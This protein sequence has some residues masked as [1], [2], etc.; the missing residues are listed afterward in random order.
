MISGILR[1]GHVRP[2]V[3][4]LAF[5][6]LVAASLAPPPA[7]AQSGYL[8]SSELE[9]LVAP[10]A[11][12]PDPLIAELLPAATYPDEVADAADYVDAHGATDKNIDRQPWDASVKAIAHYPDAINKMA[13]DMD[14][15]ADLG[16]AFLA[17]PED[18]MDAIQT[19]RGVAKDRGV[20]KT[21]EQQTVVYEEQNIRVVP[22]S[23]Q[24]I[25]VPQYQPQVVYIEDDDD[26]PSWGGAIAAS[27]ISFGVGM[28]VGSW[29]H[30]DCNWYGGG[31]YHAGWYGGY[32][33]WNSYRSGNI[34]IN[35]DVN[36]NRQV[37][38]Y[39]NF[40]NWNHD[41]NRYRNDINKYGDRYNNRYRDQNR[42]KNKDKVRNDRVANSNRNRPS[43][44]D[45]QQ[46]N[47]QSRD[48]P[49]GGDLSK[50]AGDRTRDR[51]ASADRNRDRT[52]A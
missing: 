48:R 5:C 23:D 37:N 14:W 25:Y 34:N 15:T 2:P 31:I 4:I 18:V 44:R 46:N 21:N 20:L 38:N 17:Q 27:A 7:Q 47:A 13:D 40:N 22:T 16:D 3:V 30:N 36:F 19:C 35:G 26:G 41:S 32:P 39:N 50:P 52:A 11:L 49:A 12:Y 45:R 29:F 33:S 9:V 42:A 8:S 51:T 28:A 43:T 24:V 1:R 6:A 10:I